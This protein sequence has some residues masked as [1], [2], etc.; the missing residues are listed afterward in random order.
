MALRLEKLR[1]APAGFYHKHTAPWDLP[2]EPRP[3]TAER[4][5]SQIR[6][7]LKQIGHLHAATL[8]TAVKRGVINSFDA[9]QLIGLHP[10]SFTKVEA[11]LG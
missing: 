11:A 1:L 2:T 5:L 10:E 8:L 7:R 4:Q 6:I 3:I 9:S